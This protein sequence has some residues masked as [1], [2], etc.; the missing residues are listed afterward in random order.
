[1]QNRDYR[2]AL[3][4]SVYALHNAGI[5][6]FTAMVNIGFKGVYEDISKVHEVGD[7][8]NFELSMFEGTEDQNLDIIVDAIKTIEGAKQTIININALEIA[9]EDLP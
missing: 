5:E 2:E 4:E 6:L 9:E 3:T 8:I 7:V 1:M